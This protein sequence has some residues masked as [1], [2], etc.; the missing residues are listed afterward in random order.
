MALQ[1]KM[2]QYRHKFYIEHLWALEDSKPVLDSVTLNGK[3][4]L[5]S[6]RSKPPF[7]AR[8]I[9]H[10]QE[11]WPSTLWFLGCDFFS[12]CEGKLFVTASQ[13]TSKCYKV[14]YIS[15]YLL[16]IKTL[17]S[18]KTCAIGLLWLRISEIYLWIPKLSIVY[19]QRKIQRLFM[20]FCGDWLLLHS[21]DIK[22][23]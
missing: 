17:I 19:N 6:A 15:I 5:R 3:F 10:G 2:T 16:K 9:L 7:E 12:Y 11:F 21:S 14:I 1:T 20:W 23:K 13:D 22:Q 18:R 8:S 4:K